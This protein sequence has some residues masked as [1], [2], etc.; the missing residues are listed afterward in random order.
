MQVLVFAVV[1]FVPFVFLEPARAQCD[2]ANPQAASSGLARFS[3]SLN[4][5]FSQ[6]SLVSLRFANQAIALF[7]D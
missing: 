4:F 7:F 5:S 3:N 6:L 1:F 2:A